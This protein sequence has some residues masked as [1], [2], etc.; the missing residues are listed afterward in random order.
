METC[1]FKKGK[2]STYDNRPDI[3]IRY[4]TKQIRYR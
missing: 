3:C 2:C 4:G 1:V